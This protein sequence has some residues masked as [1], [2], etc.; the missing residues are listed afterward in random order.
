MADTDALSVT[1][2][3]IGRRDI[4]LKLNHGNNQILFRLR[5]ETIWSLRP[6]FK[7]SIGDINWKQHTKYDNR[8]K[9]SSN[10]LKY[11]FPKSSCPYPHTDFAFEFGYKFKGAWVTSGAF[12]F[13]RLFYKDDLFFE[14]EF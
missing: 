4:F 5:G 7:I 2:I 8:I 11:F 10:K 1:P 6:H 3:E 12:D 13:I 9:T 14:Q